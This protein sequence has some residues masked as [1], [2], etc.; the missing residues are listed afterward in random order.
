MSQDRVYLG[1]VYGLHGWLVAG[2]GDVPLLVV[3]VVGFLTGRTNQVATK[4]LRSKAN[5]TEY[6]QHLILYYAQVTTNCKE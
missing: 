6:C 2:Y 4:L 3:R 5:R 1:R